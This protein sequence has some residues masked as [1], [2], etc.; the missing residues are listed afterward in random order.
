[1]SFQ[2]IVAHQ[3]GFDS[4]VVSAHDVIVFGCVAT[5]CDV[6]ANLRHHRLLFGG[7]LPVQAVQ[8]ALSALQQLLGGWLIGSCWRRL[9]RNRPSTRRRVVIWMNHGTR[10]LCL[11]CWRRSLFWC[12][13]FGRAGL[14]VVIS[15]GG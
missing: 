13:A 7:K 1:M 12:S 2:K 4:K 6:V 3:V 5:L 9:R 10:I 11:R 8:A 14:L 15:V